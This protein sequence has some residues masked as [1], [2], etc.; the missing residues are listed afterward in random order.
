MKNVQ[1]IYPCIVVH[2]VVIVLSLG[3]TSQA[4]D[5]QDYE[6]DAKD[7]SVSFSVKHIVVSEVRGRFTKFSGTIKLDEANIPNS[8]VTF[9]VETASIDTDNEHR[10]DDLRGPMFL[11]AAKYPEMSFASRRI[12]GS[13]RDYVLVG[14][15]N[16]HGVNHEIR[17]PFVY[18]GKVKDNM[19]KWRIGI[20]AT[21]SLNRQEWGINYNKILDNGGLVAGNEVTVQL[22]VVAMRHNGSESS[23]TG[24]TGSTKL[25][26]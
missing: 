9:T 21:F 15:M 20:S 10:D 12:E 25:H 5:L 23:A 2:A 26:R 7:S 19:G 22:D 16:L 13:G 8:S 24:A 1:T 6:V 4:A 3:A 18:N 17:V 14:N 11:D